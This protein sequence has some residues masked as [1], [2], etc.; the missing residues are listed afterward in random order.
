[1]VDGEVTDNLAVFPLAQLPVVRLVF[2]C[3]DRVAVGTGWGIGFGDRCRADA[4]GGRGS[5]T[6]RQV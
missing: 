5:I 3:N 6:D 1:M 4:G 2:N